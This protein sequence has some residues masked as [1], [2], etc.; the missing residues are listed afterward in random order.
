[1]TSQDTKIDQLSQ[2]IAQL[3]ATMGSFRNKLQFIADK[4]ANSESDISHSSSSKT[5]DTM[6]TQTQAPTSFVSHEMVC[7]EIK[8]YLTDERLSQCEAEEDF[9]HQLK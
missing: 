9:L 4:I 7:E 2:Q 8:D 5:I 3:V 1:M 6:F